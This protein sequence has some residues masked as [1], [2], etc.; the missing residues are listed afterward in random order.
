MFRQ[1]RLPKVA[2][3]IIIQRMVNYLFYILFL[4]AVESSLL[5]FVF[6]R[7]IHIRK[8]IPDEGGLCSAKDDNMRISVHVIDGFFA[9]CACGPL[10]WVGLE[11]I[12]GER[13]KR[14]EESKFKT[15]SRTIKA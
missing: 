12:R 15:S 8:E 3:S 4:L 2:Y 6:V 10:L 1:R 9:L 5:Y 11:M 13:F 7:V 14:L